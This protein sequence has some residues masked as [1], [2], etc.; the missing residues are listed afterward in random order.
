MRARSA[1]LL[2]LVLL[3]L[4]VLLALV[5]GRAARAAPLAAPLAA[6]LAASR[7]PGG[8]EGGRPP[9]AGRRPG[10]LPDPA[11][12]KHIVVD[13]LNLTHWLRSRQAGPAA[14]PGPPAAAA[15]G[16]AEIISAVDRTAPALKLRHP[17]QVI[18]VLKDRE[19]QFNEQAAHDEFQAAAVRNGVYISVAERYADPP[20]GAAPSQ[21]HSSRGRD[22]FYM[23]LLAHRYRCAVLTGDRLRDF[24]DFRA[25]IPPFHVMEYAFWRRLPHRDF[26]RPDAA[27]FARVRKPRT[28]LP[29]AYFGDGKSGDGAPA[30]RAAPYEAGTSPSSS[31]SSSSSS[32]K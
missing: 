29:D 26:V 20:A 13:T 19:T 17:G 10:R 31:S 1:A 23:G 16:R 24:A 32:S 30:G 27:A 4:A 14:P 2:L 7:P 12:S 8:V 28:V 18:Y 25:T 15:I 11:A 21:A 3:L 22:D 9:A 5:A 6:A